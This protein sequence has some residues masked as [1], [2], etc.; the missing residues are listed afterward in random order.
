MTGRLAVACALALSLGVATARA[1]DA[2]ARS[3]YDAGLAAAEAE[4][5][6]EAAEHFARADELRPSAVALTSALR[7]AIAADAPAL[8][9]TLADR[10]AARGAPPEPIDDDS[11]YVT[12]AADARARFEARAATLTVACT[13]TAELDGVAL[14]PSTPRWLDPG[15]HRLRVEIGGRVHD[16]A[17]VV[18]AGDRLE[19]RFSPPRVQP[20][21]PPPA[22]PRTVPPVPPERGISPVWFYVGL[23]VTGALA[24][25]TIASAVDTRDRYDEFE[26]TGEGQEEGEASQLRTNALFF[27][28]L[29]V[30]VV[31]AALGVFAV[32]WE[33]DDVAWRLTPTGLAGTFE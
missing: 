14:A 28:T 17:I 27:T 15:E 31:T 30:G 13:C 29:G 4:R 1:D 22:P 16:E 11:D 18:A 24:I 7:A 12:L 33:S 26:A 32:G 25:G 2:D 6:R 23:G 19:R 3:A 20:K 9:L 5:F 10:A 8:A 21:P